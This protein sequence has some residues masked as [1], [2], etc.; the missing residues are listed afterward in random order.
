MCL[1]PGAERR[2]GARARDEILLGIVDHAVA[3]QSDGPVTSSDAVMLSI[4]VI[5][6]FSSNVIAGNHLNC[7]LIVIIKLSTDRNILI[8]IPRVFLLHLCSGTQMS[9][10]RG[11]TSSNSC[12]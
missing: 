7:F 11:K 10:K 8:I 1:S 5:W 3:L 2:G 12:F 4:L 9:N 6:Q